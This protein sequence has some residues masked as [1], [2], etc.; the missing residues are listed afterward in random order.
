MIWGAIILMSWGIL[1][2]LLV[3]LIVVTRDMRR[4]AR[5]IQLGRQIKREISA[6]RWDE[7]KQLLA[8]EWR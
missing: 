3:F 5:R 6:I 8:G 7:L 4:L 1:T 2:I